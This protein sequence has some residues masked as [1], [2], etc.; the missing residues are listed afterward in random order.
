MTDLVKVTGYAIGYVI[1]GA[2]KYVLIGA[3]VALG[4]KMVM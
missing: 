2:I 4:F 1:C 3:A